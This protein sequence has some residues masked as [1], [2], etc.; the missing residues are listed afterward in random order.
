MFLQSGQ[1]PLGGF[2]EVLDNMPQSIVVFDS[3]G[4]VAFANQAAASLLERRGRSSKISHI[5]DL[6]RHVGPLMNPDGSPPAPVELP[7]ARLEREEAFCRILFRAAERWESSRPVLSFSGQSVRDIET[8]ESLRVLTIEDASHMHEHESLFRTVFERGPVPVSLVRG[9][10]QCVVDVNSSFLELLGYQRAEVVGHTVPELAVVLDNENLRVARETLEQGEAVERLELVVRGGDDSLLTLLSWQR[11]VEVGGEDCLLGVYVDIT[12]QKEMERKLREA[13]QVVLES[14]SV[15]SRSVV[16]QLERLRAPD[17]ASPV[18]GEL[19]LL[20]RRERQVV[21]R[22]GAGH[23]NLKIAADLALTPQ[24]VRN[25]VT[26]IYR[27]IGVT[28][29]SEA[30]VWARERGLVQG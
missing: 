8:G 21:T 26:R 3:G 7:A 25:Y 15:F 2:R 22:V 4:L 19:D 6:F 28:N 17:R 27:K 12:E 1:Y 29:R 11:W 5:A 30:V 9:A 10:D 13:T 14:A 24:T 16:Q 18:S 23:T 20:T